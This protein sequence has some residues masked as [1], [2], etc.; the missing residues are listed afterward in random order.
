MGSVDARLVTSTC[1][2]NMCMYTEQ[3]KNRKAVTVLTLSN[4]EK[5]T[6]PNRNGTESFLMFCDT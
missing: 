3:Y 1:L 6:Q 4:L 5:Q 2:T